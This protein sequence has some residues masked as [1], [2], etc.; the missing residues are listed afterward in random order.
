MFY[1]MIVIIT[2]PRAFITRIVQV[3]LRP[4]VDLRPESVSLS[5][6]RLAAW[7]TAPS[8]VPSTSAVDP[9]DM[10]RAMSVLEDQASD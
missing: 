1:L 3:L 2:L 4:D 10:M 5:L 6:L 9:D 8:S 7:H